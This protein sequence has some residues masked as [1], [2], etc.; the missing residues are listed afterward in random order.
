MCHNWVTIPDGVV[1][2]KY[3]SPIAY[4]TIPPST[5]VG[6]HMIVEIQEI[7]NPSKFYI[8]VLDERTIQPLDEMMGLMH[9]YYNVNHKNLE[10][11]RECV[12]EGN[13][14]A[15]QYDG[16]W[17]R[18]IILGKIG[19]V[20]EHALI[21]YIDYGTIMRIRLSELY[22][23]HHEFTRLPIQGLL[24]KS[25]YQLKTIEDFRAKIDGGIVKAVYKGVGDDGRISLEIL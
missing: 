21:Q 18:A 7:F 9:A 14:C 16:I 4:Q 22:F 10:M 6:S 24:S 25:N 12:Y 13:Y 23:L 2:S 15:A 20:D 19:M 8:N 17:H 5:T 3:D 1:M 11:V